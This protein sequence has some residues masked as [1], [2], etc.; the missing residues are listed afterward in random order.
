M[1][2]LMKG[3]VWGEHKHKLVY[4]VLAEVKYDEI[5]CHVRREPYTTNVEFLSYSGKPLCNMECW[6][7]DFG[8]FMQMFCIDSLDLGIEVNG[9][10]N[11][12]YRWVRSSKGIPKEKFDK[13]TGKTAPA[14]DV[15]MV[16]FI[17]F[18]LPD[19]I[20][21]PFYSR[22]LTR[23]VTATQAL[24]YSIPITVPEGRECA[25]EAEVDAY[26]IEV[27]E[28]GFEGLMVKGYEGRYHTVPE[29]TDQWLKM[30]PEDTVDGKITGINQ[31]FAEDGTPHN[32]AGSVD[33]ICEDG[34]TAS[35]SGIEWGLGR[36]ML[37]N[38]GK[39]IGQWIEFKFMERDRQGGYRH[40]SYVRFREAKD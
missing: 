12:S 10:F 27:R 1:P 37:E 32:R 14:L 35:P 40:P 22:K 16:R 3:Q 15:S 11:D 21:R 6:A 19:L 30:K 39:Y 7:E 13:K 36:D 31:A 23:D 8:A 2:H 18:D 20:S 26:F 5:R 33:V 28:R 29:R 34:S 38:P 9:N 4:P 17:L 24:A 25:N